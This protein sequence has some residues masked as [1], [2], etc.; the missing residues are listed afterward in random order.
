MGR[1]VYRGGRGTV[2]VYKVRNTNA[3][4]RRVETGVESCDAFAL[5][6]ASRSIESR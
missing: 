1:R 6:D 5:Y 3:E 2:V 4:E